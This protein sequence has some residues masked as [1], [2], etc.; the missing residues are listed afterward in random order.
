[1]IHHQVQTTHDDGENVRTQ[2]QITKYGSVQGG[3]AQ[4]RYHGISVNGLPNQY[5]QAIDH[6]D[7][8]ESG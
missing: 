6:P 5:Y 4:V 3:A 8:Q 2:S 1:M 7:Y